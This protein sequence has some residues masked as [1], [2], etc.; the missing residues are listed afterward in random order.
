MFSPD[1][2][3][4]FPALWLQLLENMSPMEKEKW[5]NLK[6]REDKIKF[7]WELSFVQQRFQLISN[8]RHEKNLEGSR[9][10]REAGNSAFQGGDLSGALV[11]Y[12]RS[13]VLAPDKSEDLALAYANRA[14]CL[15]RLGGYDFAIQDI[16][17]ALENKYPAKNRFK[18]EER[19]GQ[20]LLALKRYKESRVALE[21]A[22]D[23]LKFSALEEGKKKKFLKDVQDSMHKIEE[24][25]KVKD[26]QKTSAV[27]TISTVDKFKEKILKV[28]SCSKMFPAISDAVTFKYQK[29]RG[30]YAVANKTIP[31]G[32]TI[33]KEKP[34]TWSLHPDKFGSHCTECMGQIKAVIPCRT[35]CGVSFCSVECRDIA[36]NTYHRY[37]CGLLGIL[38]AS[39]LNVYPFL[40]IRLLARFGFDY[41]WNLK[42]ELSHD[43]TSGAEIE[44]S[45]EYKSEDFFNAYNLVCHEDKLDSEE[46]LLRTFVSTFLLK[47]LQ[48]NNFFSEQQQQQQQQAVE[49]SEK[50]KFIG[51]LLLHFINTLPQNVHD[52]ALME[53]ADPRRWL[54]SNQVKSLGAGV[55]CTAALYNHSCAPCF[56]RCNYGKSM[57]SVTNREIPEGDEITECYG[58]M[59]Y[60]KTLEQ[61]RGDLKKHYKFDC[62]CIA[63][64]ENWPTVKV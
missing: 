53:T 10:Q 60:T 46:F 43:E 21:A 57:V 38:V 50:E 1:R 45:S 33:L 52:I 13:V 51:T 22:V 59:Y 41:L 64:V 58:Q 29:G 42:D 19:R 34:I 55:Y 56:M 36:L 16:K 32:S 8:I 30:R 26:K 20:C 47:L 62:R 48:F 18:L 35:C 61:R 25:E 37:E 24:G 28:E 23:C 14:T 12:S 27:V 31:V 2:Q 15:Q 17:L 5:E 40:A 39:G 49:I 11:N 6:T 9:T 3:G 7:I 44:R 54:N 63:C 4:F